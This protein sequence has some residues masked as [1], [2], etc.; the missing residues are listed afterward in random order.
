[1]SVKHA[2]DVCFILSFEIL[3]PLRSLRMTAVLNA[4]RIEPTKPE[5]EGAN[6]TPEEE[7]A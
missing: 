6:G 3:R 2:Y 5:E 7:S 4:H 1:M